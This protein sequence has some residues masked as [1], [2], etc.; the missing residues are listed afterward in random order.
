[1]LISA[2]SLP[3][4]AGKRQ[5]LIFFSIR[6]YRYQP[7]S[8]RDLSSIAIQDQPQIKFVQNKDQPR[9]LSQKGSGPKSRGSGT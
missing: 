6:E 4:F 9:S 2:T 8:N 7:K 3:R 5:F 1:M